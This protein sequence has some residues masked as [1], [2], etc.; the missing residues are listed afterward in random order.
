MPTRPGP[1]RGLWDIGHEDSRTA[2]PVLKDPM[3]RSGLAF[4]G[5]NCIEEKDNGRTAEVDDG[6]ATAKELSGLQLAGTELVVLS[7]CD[8]RV[9][10][11]RNSEGVFGLRRA[12]HLAGARTVLTSLWRV[13][14]KATRLI[15]EEFY[16]NWLERGMSKGDALRQAQLAM[17]HGNLTPDSDKTR[18][19]IKDEFAPSLNSAE[20]GLSA[21]GDYAHPRYWAAFILIGDWN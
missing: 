21:R 12:F 1:E 9:G 11:V 2:M 4:A 10:Q 17:L 16:R 7:A 14:D 3:V 5:A 18:R 8:T 15:M 6:I 19:G 20:R 13:D